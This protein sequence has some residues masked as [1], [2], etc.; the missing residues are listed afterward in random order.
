VDTDP[1]TVIKMIAAKQAMDTC[2]NM[3]MQRLVAAFLR[4]G[5]LGPHLDGLRPEYRRRKRAMRDA[6][7]AHIGDRATWTDPEGGFFLWVT[8]ADRSI[9]SRRLFE[10][11]L[12]EGVAF[13][14]GP[15]FSAAGHF[16]D[17]FRL[18]FASCT[19]ERIDEGVRRLAVALDR[20]EKEPLGAH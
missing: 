8:L 19:P 14:P 13:I 6:L 4:G 15:P 20:V 3:P 9:D 7:A 17:A 2:A 1:R 12:D 18:C 10:V 11:A 16:A 5:H